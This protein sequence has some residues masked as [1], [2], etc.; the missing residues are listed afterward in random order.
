[1]YTHTHAH[2]HI[3]TH[4]CAHR[5]YVN[6]TCRLDDV[7][8]SVLSGAGYV[9]KYSYKA[10]TDSTVKFSDATCPWSQVCVCVCVCVRAR[11]CT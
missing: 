2:I 5:C 11:A 1:M 8:T 9:L 3:H 7:A 4:T 10:C 6:E